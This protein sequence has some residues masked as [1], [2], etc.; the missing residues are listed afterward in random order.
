MIEIYTKP[1]CTY[2]MQAKLLLDSKK[3]PFT[4]VRIGT[5]VTRDQFMEKF[6]DARTV[7]QITIDGKN[8]GGYTELAKYLA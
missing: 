1:S 6:P 4:E 3:I 5:D 2:C 8:I 7:P